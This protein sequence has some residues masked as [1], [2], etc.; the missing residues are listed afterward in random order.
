MSQG[1]QSGHK[2]MLEQCLPKNKQQPYHTPLGGYSCSNPELLH[3]ADMLYVFKTKQW[4]LAGTI[5][6][7]WE[8]EQIHVAVGRQ[9]GRNSFVAAS[10][11][12]HAYRRLIIVIRIFTQQPDFSLGYSHNCRSRN[13]QEN[14]IKAG[15]I[16]CHSPS[17]PVQIR[18]C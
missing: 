14:T 11:S 17:D 6:L 18:N 10:P 8:V 16:C 15:A 5:W 13:S 2:V 3:M 1:C 9:M 12:Q 7:A 4:I